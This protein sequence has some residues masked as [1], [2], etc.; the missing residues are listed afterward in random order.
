M[1]S[2]LYYVS[3]LPLLRKH[4]LCTEKK[5]KLKFSNPPQPPTS[6]YVIYEWSL[7]SGFFRP[8]CDSICLGN[9]ELIFPQTGHSFLRM[10]MPVCSHSVN[11]W[12]L[13]RCL[14]ENLVLQLGHVPV[15]Y[16]LV[17]QTNF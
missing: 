2:F 5:H 7:G 16:K 9:L 15:I 8:C 11:M 17:M 6:A 13:N 3:T 10:L 14:L 4:V 1:A 12:R